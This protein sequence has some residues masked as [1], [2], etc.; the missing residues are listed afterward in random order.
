MQSAFVVQVD[1]HAFV[2]AQSRL[3]GHCFDTPAAH[4]PVLSQVE[5]VSCEP[6]QLEL[7]VTPTLG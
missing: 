5:T 6:L 2:S 1:L 4:A 7:H 3:K